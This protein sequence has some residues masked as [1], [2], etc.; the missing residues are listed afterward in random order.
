MKSKLLLTALRPALRRPLCWSPRRPARHA[1]LGTRPPASPTVARSPIGGYVVVDHFDPRRLPATGRP[2]PDQDSAVRRQRRGHRPTPLGTPLPV[3]AGRRSGSLTSSGAISTPSSSTWGSLDTY[4][5][6]TI[7]RRRRRPGI[8]LAGGGHRQPPRTAT[9][10]RRHRT[11]CSRS[12]D[13]ARR[14]SPASPSRSRPNSFEVDNLAGRHGGVPEP[15]TWALMIMGFGMAGG[16]MRAQRRRPPPPRLASG[17]SRRPADEQNPGPRNPR[18]GF[19]R[20]R[21]LGCTQDG[22]IRRL[23]ARRPP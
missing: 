14:R 15:A 22:P 1:S 4:N 23:P 12:A 11:A 10:P 17:P 3:G 2:M 16:L 5:T 9:R 6:L 19:F 8:R 7:T 21:R 18:P 20:G 13:C